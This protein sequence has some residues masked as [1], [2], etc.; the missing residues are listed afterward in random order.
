MANQEKK[1]THHM[2]GSSPD[3]GPPM[4][5]GYVKRSDGRATIWIDGKPLAVTAPEVAS[6][7]D[8]KA[9]RAYSGRSDESFKIER[10]APR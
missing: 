7:L 6:H 4:I 5:T 9:V 10:K 1:V 2:V 3:P 8:A